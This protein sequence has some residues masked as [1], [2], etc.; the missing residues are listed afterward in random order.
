MDG[1]MESS[2]KETD[3]HRIKIFYDSNGWTKGNMSYKASEGLCFLSPPK[4]FILAVQVV[5]AAGP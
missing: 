5:L 4:G 3:V 2:K 1:W